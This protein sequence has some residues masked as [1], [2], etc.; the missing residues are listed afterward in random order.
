[1]RETYEPVL[2]ERKATQLRK[3][4]GNDRLRARGYNIEL[5]P[6]QLLRRAAV[7]PTKMLLFSPITLL[8]S[9][10]TAFGFGLSYLLFTTFPAVFEEAY[11]WGTGI[12]GLAY[13]G[14]GLGMILSIGL[15]GL[16]SDKL[17]RQPRGG[18]V[19]RPEL[20]LLLMMWSAPFSPCAFF[21]YGWSAYYKTHWI[22][23][24]MATFVMGLASFLVMMPVQ[25]Y[26]VDAFGTEAA[27]SALAANTVLRS[28]FGAFLPLAGP[29]LYA[30]LGLGW[31]NSL[32][33]FIGLCFVPIPFLFFKYGEHLRTRFPVNY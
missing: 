20:R 23:P 2:L 19:A 25:V 33:G 31:G 12:S 18:T 27:A 13:L 32:L 26:L 30:N 28:L 15:C 14:L 6:G 9:V 21:W 29:Y 22:A 5:T 4:T 11:G 3:E 7:R 17:L 1:M 10:Y 16:V 24:I 8:L